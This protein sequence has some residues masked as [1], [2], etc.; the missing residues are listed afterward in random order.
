M[1]LSRRVL[2]FA[3]FFSGALNRFLAQETL[4]GK[5]TWRIIRYQRVVEPETLLVPPLKT[6]YV[7]PNSFNAQLG[8]LKK[9]CRVIRLS[10]LV[11]MLFENSPVPPN[12]VVITFDGGW[13]DTYDRAFSELNRLGLPFTVFAPTAFIGSDDMFFR[14]KLMLGL[15][16]L[17]QAGTGYP[18]LPFYDDQVYFSLGLDLAD[19]K[20]SFEG[21]ANLVEALDSEQPEKRLFAL[22]VVGALVE[23]VGGTAIQRQFL[24]W[25]EINILNKSGVEFGLCGHRYVRLD[26]MSREE[27]AGDIHESIVTLRAH[28]IEPAQVFS[29][30]EGIISK[31][32]RAVLG[33][34]GIRCSVGV[35][36]FSLPADWQ[37]QTAVLGRVD[38]YEAASFCPEEFACR[39]WGARPFGV[40]F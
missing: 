14:D 2:A 38:M 34:L 30:P 6:S 4:N 36:N 29:Y 8:Y 21:I 22:K 10:E 3:Y 26:E 28:G 39:L 19:G 40:E 31:D 27:I 25:D 17:K 18:D 35:G 15:L 37:E 24:N 33:E 5:S 12:T 1:R 9:H 13:V 7:R 11:K 20:M 16:R 32:G 23:Q